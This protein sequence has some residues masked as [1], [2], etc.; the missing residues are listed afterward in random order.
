MLSFY[1]L[2]QNN[3]II[4]MNA[5]KY[6]KL[7]GRCNGAFIKIFIFI[8]ASQRRALLLKYVTWNTLLKQ[9]LKTLDT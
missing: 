2:E 6:F 1:K 8:R 4:I 3:D 9:N 5:Q 7:I